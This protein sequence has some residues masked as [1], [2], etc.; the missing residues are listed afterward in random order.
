MLADPRLILNLQ[1]IVSR[2]RAVFEATNRARGGEVLEDD[3]DENDELE[4]GVD[5]AWLTLI[6]LQ[7]AVAMQENLGYE[8]EEDESS[9]MVSCGRP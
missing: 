1:G 4:E 2:N 9:E 3:L 5:N 8:S 7:P 6:G